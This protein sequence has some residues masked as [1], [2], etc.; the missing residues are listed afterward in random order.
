[1]T[2]WISVKLCTNCLQETFQLLEAT[3]GHTI[4]V[5][6]LNFVFHRGGIFFF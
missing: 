4:L 1:M 3:F 2:I 6:K 5:N